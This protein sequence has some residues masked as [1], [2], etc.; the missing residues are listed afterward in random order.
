MEREV[1]AEIKKKTE[2]VGL[3]Y[4]ATDIPKPARQIFLTSVRMI[5]DVNYQP[6]PL[7]PELKKK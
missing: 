3:H 2:L 5:S 4:P 7:F 6:A 1:I